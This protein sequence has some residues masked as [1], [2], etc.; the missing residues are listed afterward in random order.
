MRLS[1]RLWLV[2]IGLLACGCV[3][4][5]DPLSYNPFKCIYPVEAKGARELGFDISYPSSAFAGSLARSQELGGQFQVLRLNWSD[6][7]GS[8]SGTT[9]GP[10]A[11]PGEALALAGRTSIDKGVKVALV[12]DP[13][14]REGKKVPD[15]LH[16]T[17][18]SAGRMRTR[19]KSLIDYVLIRLPPDNVSVLVI[20][21]E[22]DR[23]DSEG[24]ADVWTEYG[25]FLQ[26]VA[27]YVKANYPTLKT[28][29]GASYY[30]LTSPTNELDTGVKSADTFLS[31]ASYVDVVGVNYD[32]LGARRALKSPAEIP[33]DFATLAA[34]FTN[35]IH[36][37][38]LGYPSSEAA[39]TNSDGQAWFYCEALK[40]WDANQSRITRV[41]IDRLNDFDRTEAVRVAGLYGS[42]AESFIEYVRS[43]G[44]IGSDG[45]AKQS[46]EILQ[47]E[48]EERGF[49]TD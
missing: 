13:L 45:K 24:D 21:G 43:L 1:S 28:A 37:L 41:T 6:L 33:N 42:T 11:D 7:E 40:A 35:E 34:Q 17:R 8:G 10:L 46:Y 29:F 38:K 36:L 2:A 25:G 49:I 39:G 47:E 23:F 44:L 9:S 15:D 5:T 27:T 19:F 22:L 18:F 16:E 31:Y 32:G 3:P 48:L 26:N 30:A 4:W 14:S 12:I 20:G